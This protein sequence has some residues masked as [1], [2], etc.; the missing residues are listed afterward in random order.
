MLPPPA[1]VAVVATYFVLFWSTAGQTPA[2]RILRLRVLGDDGLP[3]R[4]GRS[5][6]RLVGLGLAIVPLFAGFLPALFEHRRRA[7]PDFFGGTVVLY[8]DE[9]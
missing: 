1:W 9:A 3:P 2:M 5:M 8:T 7:L 4:L 6:L